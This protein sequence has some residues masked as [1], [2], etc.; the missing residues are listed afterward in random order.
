[1]PQPQPGF[2]RHT[3]EH[4]IEVCPFVQILDVPVPQMGSQPVEVLQKIDAPELVEQVIAVPKISLDQIPQRSVCRRQRRAEQLVEVLT[5]V[6]FSSF[7]GI[8]EQIV[9]IPVPHGRGDRGGG[10][11]R[12]GS[13]RCTSR[14]GSELSADFNPWTPAACGDSMSLDGDES[15]S[16]SESVSEVE[17]HAATRFGAGFRPLRVCMRF[18][19]LHMGQPVRGCAKGDRCTFAHSWAEL[20]PEAS[21]HEHELASHLP[22]C[23]G[24]WPEGERGGAE[25][26]G[27]GGGAV[28]RRGGHPRRQQR[29]VARRASTA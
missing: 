6:S 16:G 7:S 9:D 15:E 1:M 23:G 8:V 27:G 18:L 22:E 24:E 28:R 17:E 11:G 19:E 2:Q 13:S 10:G 14:L 5:I 29:S 21:A 3:L 4:T 20:H 25:E 26:G 12:E